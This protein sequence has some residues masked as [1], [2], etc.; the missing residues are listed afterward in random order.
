MERDSRDAEIR[1]AICPANAKELQAE[2]KT[3]VLQADFIHFIESR[4][5]KIP[6]MNKVLAQGMKKEFTTLQGIYII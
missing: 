2:M 6:I 5:T 1:L 4:S 3:I